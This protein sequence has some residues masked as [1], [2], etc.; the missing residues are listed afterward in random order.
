MKRM[1]KR[2][3]LVK[4]EGYYFPWITSVEKR[5]SAAFQSHEFPHSLLLDSSPQY[6]LGSPAICLMLG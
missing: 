2:L 1:R 6:L 4:M 3:Q 5:I